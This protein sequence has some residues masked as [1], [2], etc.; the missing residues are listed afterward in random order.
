MN[1]LNG[2]RSEPG[3]QLL[4]VQSPNMG[5]ANILQLDRTQPR[6][7]VNPSNLLISLPRP[8]SYGT[9][10]RILE[11]VA[12]VFSQRKHSGIKDNPL[13]AIGEGFR[14]LLGCLLACFSV[15][16]FAYRAGLRRYCVAG[17]VESV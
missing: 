14:Q 15:D 5:R 4:A 13:V 16:C 10:H 3:V 2:S 11:P 8:L 7:N 12:E 6:L 17:H 9:A 1:V